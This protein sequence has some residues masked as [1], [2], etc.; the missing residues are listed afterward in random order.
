[1]EL[2]EEEAQKK[3]KSVLGGVIQRV[4]RILNE[5]LGRATKEE[6]AVSDLDEFDPDDPDLLLRPSDNIL[7]RR[8]SRCIIMDAF[9]LGRE[10]PEVEIDPRL[11][12][13]NPTIEQ[14]SQAIVDLPTAQRTK[15]L[16]SQ[17]TAHP[18]SSHE[19]APF[20]QLTA[21]GDMPVMS[22]PYRVTD[23]AGMRFS[24]MTDGMECIRIPEN[25]ARIGDDSM[26][27]GNDNEGPSHEVRLSGFLMDIEPV[28]MGAY[29]R[30]LN[31]VQ[32]TQ[33][34]LFDWCLL[35]AEDARCCH[36]PLTLGETG[37]QAR[38]ACET[39]MWQ[40]IADVLAAS[41]VCISHPC[42]R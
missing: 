40:I 28:S 15:S 20:T 16:A 22:A 41:F 32:P 12:F 39:Q 7:S 10:F 11:V 5:R 31:I 35:P 27:S 34:E 37:W 25:T 26:Q 14:L 9:E 8:D 6:A 19:M 2:R 13:D 3:A 1:M 33:D 21:G 4:S 42:A 38:I 17:S 24:R 18:N 36:I 23:T 29:A 30:F